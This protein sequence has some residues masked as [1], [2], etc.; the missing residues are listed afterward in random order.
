MKVNAKPNSCSIAYYYCD[1]TSPELGRNKCEKILGTLLRQL[2]STD[3]NR[4]LRP[5]V[6]AAYKKCKDEASGDS[7]EPQELSTVDC[8]A[9]AKDLT[10]DYQVTIMIDA[11]DECDDDEQYE[12]L[13]ALD[14]IIT[15]S[16]GLVKVFISSRETTFLVSPL[17]TKQFNEL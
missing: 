16:E 14:S 8:I 11:V 3:V 15:N 9:L 1:K 17:F 4:P 5:A 7:S 10:R 13:Q 6:V 12:L 2:A